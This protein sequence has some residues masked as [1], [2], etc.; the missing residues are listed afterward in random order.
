MT[1]KKR[2]RHPPRRTAATPPAEARPP[3]RPARPTRSRSERTGERTAPRPGPTVIAQPRLLPSLGRGLLTVGRS[4]ALLISAFLGLLVLWLI[5]SAAA[6]VYVASPGTLGQ[7][8]SIPPMHSLVDANFLNIATR[9]FHPAVTVALGAGLILV[10]SVLISFWVA[11]SLE[12]LGGE[13]DWRTAA[14]R[15]RPR[16]LRSLRTVLAVEALFLAIVF[17]V[18]S[19]L[20]AALGFLGVMASIVFSMYFL[21]F[22]PVVAVAELTGLRDS[23]RLAFRAARA[24]GPQHT[25]LVFLY[26]SAAIML[27][28]Y[29]F[30]GIASAATPS[31]P[32]WLYGLG[33]SAVHVAILATFVDRWLSLR[34]QVTAAAEAPRVAAGSRAGAAR[35][36]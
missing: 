7:L 21:V 32:T 8:E 16:A 26:T 23:L 20:G 29:G 25:L 11:A 14:R 22:T 28:V 2:R 1:K 34:D 4:P 10:R 36:R 18:P 17:V 12:A 30:G 5:A 15:A 3:A 33:F 35:R 6:E 19:V 31:I 24:R 13:P 27:L 9:V